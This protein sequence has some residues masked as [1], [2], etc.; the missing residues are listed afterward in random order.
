MICFLMT[1]T[2]GDGETGTEQMIQ[3]HH[4]PQAIILTHQC[5]ADIHGLTIKSYAATVCQAPHLPLSMVAAA[6]ENN[7]N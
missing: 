2:S 5:M 3:H 7:Q 1:Q 6:P 4:T